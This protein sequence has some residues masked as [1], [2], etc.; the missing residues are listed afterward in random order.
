M[1]MR[2]IVTHNLGLK[3]LSLLLAVALWL[4]VAAEKESETA[5]SVPVV[6][7]NIPPGLVIAGR[8]PARVDVRVAG[9][10]ILLLKLYGDRPTLHLNLKDARE[11]ITAFPALDAAIRIRKGVRVT[12][13][14]P[15]AMEVGLARAATKGNQG[16]IP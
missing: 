6:F 5:L 12:R 9:P 16:E 11:G 2:D 1:N 10:K 7:E 14:T 15:A 4:F 13:V 3:M 8:P